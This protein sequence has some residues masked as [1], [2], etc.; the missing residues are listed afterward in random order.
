M[1]DVS[2]LLLSL[3]QPL[4]V[5]RVRVGGRVCALR[6]SRDVVW[7]ICVLS[8]NLPDVVDVNKN[9]PCLFSQG[10]L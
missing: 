9:L 8:P 6:F 4:D 7:Y 10:M 2:E 3:S 5:E 1:P